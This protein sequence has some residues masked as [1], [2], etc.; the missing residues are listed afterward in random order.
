[1]INPT[2]RQNLLK[3]IDKNVSRIYNK[4][5]KRQDRKRSCQSNRLNNRQN[6]DEW[7]GYFTF[8]VNAIKN[9]IIKNIILDMYFIIATTPFRR[10]AQPPVK[11]TVKKS[12]LIGLLRQLLLYTRLSYFSSFIVKFRHCC[13]PL[14]PLQFL[15]NY[16]IL[17]LLRILIVFQNNG[18]RW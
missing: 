14:H 9:T 2:D 10:V 11:T 7:G 1:M 15:G 13:F 3:S 4:N 16:D 12:R 6:F 18:L 8:I 5:R 17:Y